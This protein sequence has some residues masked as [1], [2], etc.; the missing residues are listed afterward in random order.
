MAKSIK[1][2]EKEIAEYEELLAEPSVPAD[3]KDFA[4]DEI[5]SLKE[6]LAKMQAK[7]SKPEKKEAAAPKPKEERKPREP[8]E[9]KAKAEKPAKK[10]KKGDEPSC[11]DLLKAWNERR[12][13]AKKSAKKAKTRSVFAIIADKVEDAV[14][15]AIKT[16]PASDIKADPQKAINRFEKLEASMQH[17]L[18]DF[19]TVLGDDYKA[20]EVTD[21]VKHIEDLIKKLKTRYDK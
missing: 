1:A 20:S 17:F 7:E 19:R 16:V 14:T 12:S 13:A 15:K 2:I 9:P 11:D 21:A 18:Q 3:E 4:R 10:A 8:K 5:K 6:E